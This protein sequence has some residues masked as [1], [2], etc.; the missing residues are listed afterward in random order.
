MSITGKGLRAG[1]TGGGFIDFLGARGEG[2]MMDTTRRAGL[3]AV[4]ASEALG[5]L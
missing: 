4:T 3:D 5:D 1:V 2:S